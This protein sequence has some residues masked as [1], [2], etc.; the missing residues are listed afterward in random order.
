M[1]QALRD[2]TV[3]QTRSHNYLRQVK[4]SV[5]FK[6]LAVG[7]SFFSIP[8]MIHYLGKEQFGVWSTLLSLMTWFVFFDF[9]LGHGLRN[10]LGEA[11]AKNETI[12]ASKYVSSAYSL[13][14]LIALGIFLI[15]VAAA[16]LVPWQRV[17]NT[18]ALSDE[19]L[20]CVVLITGFFVALNFWVGLIN[21]V[22]NAAQK[23][24]TVVFGQFLSN[25]FSLVM[26]YALTKTTDA[27][28]LYLALAY[29]VSLVGANAVLSVW[30]YKENKSLT[31]KV[32]PYPNHVR[33]LLTLGLQFFAIQIAVLIIYSTSNILI[34]QL[35]G[36]AF[37]TQFEV[38]FKLFSIITLA[39]GLVSAPLWSSYTDA[40]HREDFVWIKH[41]LRTQIN[42]FVGI[43]FAVI[44]LI[45]VANPVITL[46]IGDDINVS[47][48]LVFS[49]GVFILVSTWTN[50]F[51][52]FLNGVGKIRV[53]VIVSVA[54]MFLNI[55]T[56][57]LLAKY[58]SMDASA[59]VI[60][61]VIAL[62][63]GVFSGPYQTYK[64]LTC[65]DA[66]IWGR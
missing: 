41:T 17:F 10:K 38:V 49:V 64:I 19:S 48:M 34:A 40:Y 21:P 37:V 31:P 63:P 42:I 29:G 33:P 39:Y 58:T 22:L 14:A 54:A 53:S 50:I 51:A 59:V 36:P 28:M 15:A 3:S 35:F 43:V 5:V 62:L 52:S 2:E 13:I 12:E 9:G 25:A 1:A 8:L 57:I 65:R 24:S 45:L 7:C 47:A 20:G 4:R 11:L 6:G 60:G 61:M 16:F 27:T 23:T 55:P 26:V 46:W 66:G 18:Q 32:S 44:V 56:A 30:F